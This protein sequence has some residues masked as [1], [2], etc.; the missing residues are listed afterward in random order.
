MT[1]RPTGI[2]VI[3]E[4][5]DVDY[6]ILD[7]MCLDKD[8]KLLCDGRTV[9]FPSSSNPY[10]FMEIPEGGGDAPFKVNMDGIA[11]DPTFDQN[12]ID[13]TL[14]IAYYPHYYQH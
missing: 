2:A 1:H 9:N 3:P 12:L 4:G 8:G 14:Y 6:V 11:S 7:V 5:T 13:Q 10:N